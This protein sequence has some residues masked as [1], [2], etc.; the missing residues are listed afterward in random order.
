M[1]KYLEVNRDEL[2]FIDVALYPTEI[3]HQQELLDAYI[4]SKE[5]AKK[6]GYALLETADSGGNTKLVLSE[7]ECWMLR[8][9]IDVRTGTSTRPKLGFEL[10]CKLYEILLEFETDRGVIEI[11][12]SLPT[13]NRQEKTADDVKTLL[14]GDK[15]WEKRRRR[16]GKPS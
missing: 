6:V 3:T 11:T 14:A 5:L 7:N 1:P 16:H 12:D 2:I 9:R 10:K 13:G 4:P 15:S 8:E